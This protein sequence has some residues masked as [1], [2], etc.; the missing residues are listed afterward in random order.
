MKNM[1]LLAS[2]IGFSIA[3]NA[4]VTIVKDSRIDEL[5]RA[6]GQAIP[7]A[8]TPEIN[9]YRLQLTFDTSK[10]TIDEARSRFAAMFPKVDTYVEFIAP[11]YFLKVG[12]FRTQLEAEKVKAATTQQFPTCFVVKEKINLPRIDQ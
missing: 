1:I 11:H 4:Q 5:V 8:T 3:G 6:Q 12:D 2:F 7:P 9:G 10:G